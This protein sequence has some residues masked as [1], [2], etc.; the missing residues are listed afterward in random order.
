MAEPDSAG[1]YRILSLDGGGAKG[2]Y[3]LGV[4]K[5]VEGL[6]GGTLC[7]HFHLIFGTSTGSIIA[8]FLALGHRVD[9]IRDLYKK[10]VVTVTAQKSAAS[11]SAALERLR[12][13]VFGDTKFDAVKTAIG[14]V[15]TKWVI[16]RPMIFKASVQQA[17]GRVGTFVPG[18]RCT[19]GDAVEA[20]C[21]AYPYF[22][23]KTVRTHAGE[24]VDLVDGGYCANNPTLY[25]TNKHQATNNW[26]K[27]TVRI[28]KNMR[29]RM[30]DANMLQGV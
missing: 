5:E 27:P 2:F 21:S 16:E 28:Y 8:A 9:E 26:F 12:V 19:I 18:F 7:E 14:I 6:V 24:D 23:L 29:N 22:N 13:E 17:H 15:A 11:K 10:H 4:L 25:A 1:N 20:S 30:I 3:T